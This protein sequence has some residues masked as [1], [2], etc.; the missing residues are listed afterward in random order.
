MYISIYIDIDRFEFMNVYM[1]VCMYNYATDQLKQMHCI[2]DLSLIGLEAIDLTCRGA[3]VTMKDALRSDTWL[4]CL[5]GRSMGTGNLF[6]Y[7]CI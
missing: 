5:K 3:E 7:M 6:K 4:I 1:Y 2:M